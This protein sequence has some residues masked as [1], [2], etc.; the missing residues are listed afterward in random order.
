[1]RFI[2]MHVH[3]TFSDGVYSPGKLVDYAVEKGLSGIAITDHDTVDGIEEAIKRAGIYKNFIVIP[4]VELSTEYNNEEIHIL[5]YRIDYK[6]EYLLE[7]LQRL[8]DSRSDRATKIINKLKKI[9]VKISY[10]DVTKIAGDGAIGRPHIAHSLVQKGYVQ[11]I[12]EAFI[13]YLAK[14]A[15]AYVPK[16]KLTPISAINIIKKAGGFS[17]AAHPGLLK[18]ETTLD[19]LIDIGIDGIEVYHSKHTTEQSERYLKLAEKHNLIITGGSDFHYPPK[20]NRYNSNPDEDLGGIKISLE[21]IK[22]LL[23]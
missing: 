11:T 17:V 8:Q 22:K 18:S 14:G 1:M 16:Q 10:K 7:I 12:K 15:V 20:N 6:M 13:R 19:Y 5:G 23:K 2:D 21:S 4:G 3:S 9:G